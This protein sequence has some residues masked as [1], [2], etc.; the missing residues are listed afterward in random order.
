MSDSEDS[1]TAQWERDQM[2]RGTQS[3]R[4]R[5]K[6]PAKETASEL[7][8]VSVAKNHVKQNMIKIEGEL[9]K[10]KAKI[11]GG[12]EKLEESKRRI[13]SLKRRI[14]ELEN[15]SAFFKDIASHEKTDDV[16]QFITQNEPVIANLTSD[17]EEMIRQLQQDLL[18][19]KMDN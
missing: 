15:H 4:V 17:Q 14:E 10:L 9:D 19:T 8:D 18:E 6:Q 2:L 12:Q 13:E 16:L 7:I 3:K 11:S 1:E 5:S